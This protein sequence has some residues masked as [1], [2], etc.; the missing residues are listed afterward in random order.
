MRNSGDG[1]VDADFNVH[2]PRLH[3]T[4]EAETVEIAREKV[5]KVLTEAG[6]NTAV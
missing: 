3:N 1:V 5:A 6:Y 4:S 2:F